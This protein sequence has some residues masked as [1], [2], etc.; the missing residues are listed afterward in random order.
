[1]LWDGGAWAER[2]VPIAVGFPPHVPDI[3]FELPSSHPVSH[4][5]DSC[6]EGES[7]GKHHRR[8]GVRIRLVVGEEH[9]SEMQRGLPSR[10]EAH[11][12]ERLSVLVPEG[13]G[14]RVDIESSSGMRPVK[15]QL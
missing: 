7:L 3:E 11:V 9:A 8:S 15:L 5:P 12:G 6:P 4:R 13:C 14:H 1:M 2:H 10:G